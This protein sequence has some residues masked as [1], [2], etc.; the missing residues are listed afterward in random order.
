MKNIFEFAWINQSNNISLY[1]RF[2]TLSWS[3]LRDFFSNKLIDLS[4][5]DLKW[6]DNFV[7]N[8]DFTSHLLETEKKQHVI[9]FQECV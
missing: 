3:Y 6:T 5:S 9:V 2:W 7:N 1:I 4:A 8:F